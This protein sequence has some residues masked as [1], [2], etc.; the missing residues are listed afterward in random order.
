M[1]DLENVKIVDEEKQQP[2]LG[3]APE[4]LKS[5]AGRRKVSNADKLTRV[6]LVMLLILNLVQWRYSIISQDPSKADKCVQKESALR[7]LQDQVRSLCLDRTSL[8]ESVKSAKRFARLPSDAGYE[9]LHAFGDF[10]GVTTIESEAN[11]EAFKK[12]AKALEEQN[13]LL[14][15]MATTQQEVTHPHP[16]K[17]LLSVCDMVVL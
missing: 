17:D 16:E 14:H 9:A 1:A 3:S 8:L 7:Q 2:L 15:D 4:E 5:G 10:L 12:V 11:P 6:V 13:E